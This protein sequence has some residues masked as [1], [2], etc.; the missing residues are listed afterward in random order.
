MRKTCLLAMMLCLAL[1][2]TTA[3]N[4]NNVKRPD[5]YN[6]NR[7]LE[8]LNNNNEEEALNYFK[9]EL[10]ND[11]KNGYAYTWIAIIYAY[12]AQ[13]GNA[14]SA[15]DKAQKYLPKKDVEFVSSAYCQKA[16]IY[17][18]LADT[19]KALENITAAIKTD[20]KDEDIY[21]KRAQVYYELKQ[22]D[23]AD[24]D[25]ETVKEMN[26][27]SH[28]GY[29][30]IGRNRIA[31]ER[32]DEAIEQFNQVIALYADNSQA[33]AFR[34]KAYMGKGQWHEATDDI[35][36][37]LD[38]EADNYA[39]D[40]LLSIDDPNADTMIAKLKVQQAKKPNEAKWSFFIGCIYKKQ[41][42]YQKA[43][44]A[45]Q[46][47]NKIES[48]ATVYSDIADCYNE[49]GN[50][51]QAVENINKAIELRPDYTDYLF[52]K[53]DLLYDMGKSKEAI[54]TYDDY[55][56]ANPDYWGG[57]YRR[58][59]MKDNTNDVD[60]AIEDYSMAITLEPNYAYS[61]LGRGDMYIR[62]GNKEAAMKDYQKVVE[63][64]T[65][66]S[67]SNCIQY[68]LLGL[69]EVERAKAAEDSILAHS[70]SAGNYYDAACLYA[71]MN[72]KETALGYLRKSFENGFRRFSHVINDDDLEQ[73]REM[74]AFKS[75]IKEFKEKADNEQQSSDK[76][77]EQKQEVISEIPFTKEGSI[78]TVKCKINDLPLHFVFDTG[79]S[80]VSLSMVEATF[81]MKNGYLTEKDVIGSQFFSDANGNVN[82]GTVIN[83]RKV[84]FGDLELDN[85]RASVVRNQR[86]TLLLGQSVLSKAGKI[87]IDNEKLVIR[88]KYMK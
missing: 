45:F 71:R 18:A 77:K 13:Y 15:L 54:E 53:G 21:K 85:I 79:A 58:A 8:E 17:L 82:E 74:D 11:P 72:E 34:A 3:Q 26:Q 75:L 40:L 67:E 25:Y 62:K 33:Y 37:S 35:I 43:I 66:Y 31:Q 46:Q 28:L 41:A 47:S 32:W 7:G 81:M 9:K 38:L 76:V 20:P 69:G 6:Y 59:F 84:Q 52:V 2:T 83:L 68:A 64:D 14:L 65:I 29:V 36:K 4:E 22:Y 10:E 78:C 27:A 73:V 56:K 63:L 24:S 44:E 5:T 12:N 30:G 42:M 86:A 61:Y 57:Y 1:I 48:F 39:Y 60:G 51:E 49:L 55:I 23:K 70:P 50:Y 16:D 19:I 80:T 87:E 88:V